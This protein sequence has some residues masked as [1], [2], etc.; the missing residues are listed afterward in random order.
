MCIPCSAAAIRWSNGNQTKEGQPESA[1]MTSRNSLTDTL[2]IYD[3][4]CL[5]IRIFFKIFFGV[6]TDGNTLSANPGLYRKLGS[7]PTAAAMEKQ[8]LRN[9]S[10]FDI[11]S[12]PFESDA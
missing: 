3:K 12:C 10:N 8:C 1:S 5:G 4:L 2:G 6:L 9:S 7:S 11:T